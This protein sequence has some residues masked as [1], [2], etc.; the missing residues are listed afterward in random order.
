MYLKSVEIVG[1]KSFA[2]KTRLDLGSGI[3]GIVGPNGCGKSNV[4]ESVRWAIGETSWKSLRSGSMVDVI[5]S[6][7]SRRQG[8]SAAEVNL[9]FDN[10][11]RM[12]PLDFSEVTVT[13]RIYRSG[14]CEYYINKTQCRRKDIQELFLDTGAGEEGYSI[15]DQGK[16]EMVLASKPEDRR[17]LF[18]EAAGVAKYKAKRQEALSKL[19]KVEIDL[20]RLSDSMALIQEQIKKLDSDARK[21]RLYQKYRQDLHSMECAQALSEIEG[22]DS[23][24]ESERQ[25]LEP[26][27]LALQDLGSKATTL[28]AECAAL[29]LEKI[30]REKEIYAFNEKTSH[31]KSEIARLEERIRSAVQAVEDLAQR[32]EALESQG[33]SH[34]RRIEELGPEMEKAS[35]E[36]SRA[37]EALAQGAELLNG[38][39]EG[40]TRA[41]GAVQSE[42]AEIEEGEGRLL[43]L[44]EARAQASGELSSLQAQRQRQEFELRSALKELEKKTQQKENQTAQ[45]DAIVLEIRQ[46]EGRLQQSH[47]LFYSEDL[48]RRWTEMEIKK[49][50]REISEIKAKKAEGSAR[51]EALR[52]QVRK[53][54]YQAGTHWL[55]DNPV[56]GLLGRLRDLIDCPD[57]YRGLVEDVLG[58]RL[59]A[60]ICQDSSSAEEALRAL[61]EAQ[62]GRARILILQAIPEEGPQPMTLPEG[63]RLLT[64][65]LK[66]SPPADRVV[67]YLLKEVYVTKSAAYGPYWV[68]GGSDLKIAPSWTAGDLRAQQE[69][70]RGLEEKESHHLSKEQQ[71]RG[72]LEGLSLRCSELEKSY[73]EEEL[74]LA[75][76][77]ER[78]AHRETE[79]SLLQEETALLEKES[80]QHLQSI[81]RDM[82][83]IKE[84]DKGYLDLKS[85]EEELQGLLK[86][87]RSRQ[88]TL[89]QEYSQKQLEFSQAE[90]RREYLASTASLLRDQKERLARE[91]DSLGRLLEESRSQ[92]EECRSKSS[93]FKSL[94]EQ[95]RSLLEENHSRLSE[96]ES[97][98]KQL[99]EGLEGLKAVCLGKE[100]ELKA[101]QSEVRQMQ[102]QAHHIQLKQGQ[103]ESRREMILRHMAGQLGLDQEQGSLL[104]Q[105]RQRACAALD[106]EKPV[107]P[108][109]VESL[110]R[111]IENMGA[112]NMAAPEEYEA[113][114]SRFSFLDGQKT[115][116]SKAK[117]DL[118]Q[119]I[120]KINA[121]TRENF[122]QTFEEVRENFRQV[123]AALFEGG[124]ADLILTNPDDLLESGVEVVAQPPGKKLQ[125]ISLLSGG[126]KALTAIALLF[127]FFKVRPSPFYVLDEVD[128]ALDEANIERFVGLL[129]QFAEKSQFLIISHNKRTMEAAHVIYGVT[130][131]ESGV[132]Q[133]ISVELEKKPQVSAQIPARSEQRLE[134]AGESQ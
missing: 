34:E 96:E 47:E 117:E 115:D 54:P 131:E 92:I 59:Q 94:Q 101:V 119:A 128:A 53:D 57:Q 73:R 89:R 113:L 106:K 93:E 77:K 123:Y 74:S 37:E 68:C 43:S 27:E 125:S 8:L 66:M 88:E 29:D 76:L 22:I 71:L 65:V 3:T 129:K 110:R 48:K 32:R 114:Q 70:L 99:S 14:E 120:A 100:Q 130:M 64:S 4:V 33:Q 109:A 87:A 83:R 75:G 108:E 103:M 104:D 90:N 132:S 38:L 107:T 60:L 50:E 16:V 12:L 102:E 26:I 35:Q 122:R 91:K 9:T 86:D 31:I 58:E 5:F 20:N 72:E 52:I 1:F 40:L 10:S 133:L 6:G 17:T 11:S 97:Q 82:A 111:R 61:E 78:L 45:K 85:R 67:P 63:A 51:I 49:L 39:R 134:P 25:A 69:E 24:L 21:A 126:E 112:I 18:E 7:T 56:P 127:S 46:K 36:L 116:L 19:E 28:E 55:L 42:S 124:E 62:Q 2:D 95:C 84:I 30:H 118:R 81:S 121:T 80:Q 41:Q 105:I 44:A 23:S 98:L 79:L 13:R 15:M